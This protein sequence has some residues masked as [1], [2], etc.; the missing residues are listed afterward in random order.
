M[1]YIVF[2]Q[3]VVK[4]GN[5]H[6]INIPAYLIRAGLIHP[7]QEYHIK[8]KAIRSKPRNPGSAPKNEEQKI[9]VL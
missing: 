2:K 8:F 5:S 6:S 9:L 3:R 7:K 4:S 1:K